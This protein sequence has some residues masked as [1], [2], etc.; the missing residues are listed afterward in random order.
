MSWTGFLLVYLLGGI[1]FIPLVVAVVLAHAYYTFP[2]RTDVLDPTRITTATEPAASTSR[3][4]SLS[5]DDLVQPGDDLSGLRTAQA[6]PDAG[7]DSLASADKDQQAQA[8][9]WNSHELDVASGYFA[10]C[11]EYTPMGI[12]AKPIERSTPVGSATVA[13]PSQSVYQT[14]YRTIF[15]RKQTPGPLD[16]KNNVSQR[17]KKAGNVFYVVLR[18]G[19]LMLFD[20]EEQL[21]VRHVIS[22]AHH[23][24]SI[25]S[26]GDTT[27]EGELWI[28]R[29]ALCLSR[30]KDPTDKAADSQTSKPFYLFSEN[31]SAKEDFYFALLRNQDLTF[32]GDSKAPTPLGFDVKDILSLVQRL[33][34]T[35]DHMHTRWLN[36][37]IGRVFLSINRTADFENFIREKLT[38]KISRVKRPTFLSDISIRDIDPGDS[39]PWIMNPRLRDLNVEGE[40]VVEADVRYTG[41][42]R[43]EVA[44]TV[45]IDLGARF[46]VREVDLVLAVVVRKIEGH[47]LFKVKPPPSNRIW[48]T[49][50]SMPKIEMTIEPIV[51]ARQITY[52]VILRQIENR[53]KEVIAETMV[54]PSWDDT[55]FFKTEHKRWRGGIFEG[56]D[57]VIKESSATSTSTESVPP[58]SS[59]AAAAIERIQGDHRDVQKE[60]E[61]EVQPGSGDIRQVEKSYSLPNLEASQSSGL[62]SRKGSKTGSTRLGGNGSSTSLDTSTPEILVPPPPQSPRPAHTAEPAKPVVVM[63]N[64]SDSGNSSDPDQFPEAVKLVAGSSDDGNRSRASFSSAASNA[65]PNTGR[66]NSLSAPSRPLPVAHSPSHSSTSSQNEQDLAHDESETASSLAPD[67]MRR[68]NTASSSESTDKPSSSRPPLSPSGSN[69][70][71]I[72]S[73]TGSIGSNS[74]SRRESLSS[75]SIGDAPSQGIAKRTTLAAVT[76]AA[77]QATAQARQWGWNAIQRRKEQQAAKRA[78]TN[79]NGHNRGS[80]VDLSQPM[81]GGR[82]FPPPGTPLPGPET[83]PTKIAPSTSNSN[84]HSHYTSSSNSASRPSLPPRPSEAERDHH[85]HH[86]HHVDSSRS[87]GGGAEL[88]EPPSV[89]SRQRLASIAHKRGNSEESLMVVAAPEESEPT[90]PVSESILED[91][92]VPDTPQLT[93]QTTQETSQVVQDKTQELTGSESDE[94]APKQLPSPPLLV[95][96]D[97][98]VRKVDVPKGPGDGCYPNWVEG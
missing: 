93:Q 36:A 20:D 17:P 92:N 15:E 6:R 60:E 97:H 71:S 55:P 12:N 80:S 73:Q 26:G 9:P 68:R 8:K 56:D 33:H 47:M 5:Q 46:K 2:H 13:A 27:P 88:S 74:F 81:G 1:T 32:G 67:S 49:F 42:F 82:P 87:R 39:A 29:S 76:S 40:C 94:E 25:Y 38:T 35:E 45:R 70:P 51:S 72:R 95:S 16:D 77:A 98:G 57:A 11:R 91:E 66:P 3:S 10:V 84:L 61:D 43:I 52:T 75:T 48:Q 28:K 58:S 69:A 78:A 59:F 90:T 14:M 83:P 37:L 19:H 41:N 21:E 86:H 18:H 30:K 31:C 79:T 63:A 44:T 22:L 7:A 62:F 4:R 23:D 54:L 89:L 64:A 85:H 96:D 65:G 53:I 24:V 34:S 50:Q